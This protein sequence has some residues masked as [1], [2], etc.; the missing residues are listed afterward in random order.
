MMDSQ[1]ST[2]CGYPANPP[3]REV[4]KPYLLAEMRDACMRARKRFLSGGT[5]HHFYPSAKEFR[6]GNGR[7][8]PYFGN[9]EGNDTLVVRTIS[10]DEVV[11]GE[12]EAAWLNLEKFKAGRTK[13]TPR[14]AGNATTATA[15]LRRAES[16]G[17]SHE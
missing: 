1:N 9:L 14:L 17:A 5:V 4:H 3:L 13:S 7:R 10:G 8:T 11:R 6:R 2:C 12:L 15:V 16:G